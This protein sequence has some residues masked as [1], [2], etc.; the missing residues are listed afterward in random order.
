MSRPRGLDAFIEESQSAGASG[1][2]ERETEEQRIAREA[3]FVRAEQ[4]RIR[5]AIDD[6]WLAK[7]ILLSK[8][9][10]FESEI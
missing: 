5:K 9:N 4:T 1:F 7:G 6:E 8:S 2:G 10:K 3:R